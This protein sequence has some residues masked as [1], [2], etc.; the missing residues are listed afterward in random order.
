MIETDLVNLPIESHRHHH[1]YH[2]MIIGLSG[3]ADFEVDG[4]GSRLLRWQGCVVPSDHPHYYS[5]SRD[6]RVLVLNLPCEGNGLVDD[7]ILNRLFRQAGYFDM[8]PR[9]Q[10]LLQLGLQEIQHYPDDRRLAAHIAATFI[11]GL[12]HRIDTSASHPLPRGRAIDRAQIDQYLDT[13]LSRTVSI[14]ELAKLVHLSPSQFQRAFKKAYGMTPHQYLIAKRLHLA[15]QLL[16]DT[17]LSISEVASRCGFS[18]QSAL[19]SS[20]R[21]YQDITP[22][23][24]RR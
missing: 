11:H 13:H 9:L 14:F 15:Q 20:F 4:I 5:G 2:Q 23:K 12:H 10:Q 21:R 3:R 6:N 7:T 17:N 8:D 16:K 22:G 24:L 19:T 18:S 1:A